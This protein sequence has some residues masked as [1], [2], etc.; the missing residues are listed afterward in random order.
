MFNIDNLHPSLDLPVLF[1]ELRY[2]ISLFSTD[3]EELIVF[4][5]ST[6][7]EDVVI[8][9]VKKETAAVE[10]LTSQVI[11]NLILYPITHTKKDL[12]RVYLIS[13]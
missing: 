3:L 6:A 8:Q 13:C 11:I 5:C 10:A 1:P 7:A 4:A 2:G 12:T 9:H